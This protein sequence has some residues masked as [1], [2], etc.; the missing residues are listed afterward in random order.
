METNKTE[1]I[2]T[3]RR[4]KQARHKGGEMLSPCLEEGGRKETSK[5]R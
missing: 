4:K 2:K 5:R 3:K 1:L